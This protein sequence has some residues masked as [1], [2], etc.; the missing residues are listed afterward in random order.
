MQHR[1]GRRDRA[2]TRVLLVGLT[3]AM[4]RSLEGPLSDSADVSAVPFPSPAFYETARSIAPDLV[5]VDVTYLAEERVRPLMLR[6]FANPPAVIVFAS[7][8]GGGWV[9][10]LIR[11]RSDHLES[12]APDKLFGLLQPR[13]RLV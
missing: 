7:E 11:G 1:P 4:M 6:W 12:S 9:D 10:D 3:P 13:L 5:V 8:A 2:R